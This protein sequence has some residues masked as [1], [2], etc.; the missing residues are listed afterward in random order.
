MLAALNVIIPTTQSESKP[1]AAIALNGS[2]AFDFTS[3]QE[4]SFS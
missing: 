4:S 3:E 1:K 2:L